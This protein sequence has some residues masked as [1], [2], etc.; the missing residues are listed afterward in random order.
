MPFFLKLNTV[1]PQSPSRAAA[2]SGSWAAGLP[3][4]ATA[5]PESRN[6]SA[7]SLS[8]AERIMFSSLAGV[9]SCVRRRLTSSPR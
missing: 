4:G 2:T 9:T 8:A 6:T 3:F 1:P 7:A 5:S